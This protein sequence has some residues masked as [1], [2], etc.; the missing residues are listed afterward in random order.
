MWNTAQQQRLPQMRLLHQTLAGLVMVEEKAEDHNIMKSE[1]SFFPM[2]SGSGLPVATQPSSHT[3]TIHC[4]ECGSQRLW[5]DGLR[6]TFYGEI[7]RYIC[8]GCSY[9]FSENGK[10][11]NTYSDSSD[12]HNEFTQ[13]Y[14]LKIKS[15]EDKPSNRS[16]HGDLR[17]PR[18]GALKS[19]TV[20]EPKT[21]REPY[22]QYEAVKAMET[23]IQ[24]KA[25]GATETD[26]ATIKGKMVNFIWE[27][28][29]QGLKER[30]IETYHQHLR[31][32][33]KRGVDLLDPEAVKADIAIQKWSE[34]TKSLAIASYSKFLEINDGTWKPPRYR[35]TRKIPF[36]PLEEEL[37]SLISGAYPKMAAFL[38]VLK[39]TGMRSGEAL[40]LKWIEVDFKNGA[41]TLNQTEK[42]GKPRMFKISSALLSMLN[43][44]P[45]QS[46]LIFGG[47]NPRN[48]G[49]LYRKLRNR[50]ATNFRIQD[51]GKSLSTPSDTG[52]PQQNTTRRKTSFMSCKCWATET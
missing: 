24:E 37:N 33:I 21:R 12:K 39:E 43:F 23:R 22:N 50:M 35:G 52:K 4:P 32:L 51:S 11:T 46:D 44:L 36:I 26:N 40:H 13:S 48:F 19:T 34:G 3:T 6:Y 15:G 20:P 41:L 27:L 25:A 31:G 29:K 5:K 45:K 47:Q 49:G 18:N 16:R 42:F 2:G 1:T 14:A 28:Q 38:Q 17:Y 7:Q 8:R 9:R 10:F 30:S